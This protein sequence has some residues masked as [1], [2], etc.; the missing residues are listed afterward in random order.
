MNLSGIVVT[1]TPAKL[2]TV[3]SALADLPGVEVH[4]TDEATA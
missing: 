3:A 1:T 2:R 4:H